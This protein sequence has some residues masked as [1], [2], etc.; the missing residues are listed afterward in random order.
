MFNIIRNYGAVVDFH[1]VSEH[2][3]K[4]PWMIAVDLYLKQYKKSIEN[5]SQYQE[6]RQTKVH[7]WIGPGPYDDDTPIHEY[8]KYNSTRKG[9]LGKLAGLTHRVI[10]S[11]R[12]I[13]FGRS[14]RLAARDLI[15]NLIWQEQKLKNNTYQNGPIAAVNFS[16]QPQRDYPVYSEAD[17]ILNLMLE[18]YNTFVNMEIN[19]AA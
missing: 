19:P 9:V 3:K 7:I 11:V 12:G 8:L 10:Q 17:R 16:T 5:S 15:V 1:R 14:E 18:R 4:Q 2:L 6:F 13:L